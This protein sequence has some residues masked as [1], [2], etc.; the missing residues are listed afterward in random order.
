MQP[1]TVSTTGRLAQQERVAELNADYGSLTAQEIVRTAASQLFFDRLACV[2][3]FGA[4]AAVLLHMVSHYAASAPVVFLDTGKHF[5]ETHTYVTTLIKELGLGVVV[6]AYPQKTRIEVE[7]PAGDLHGRDQDRCCH[8]RK[9]QPMLQALRPYQAF[10][11]GRKRSQTLDRADLQP[12]EAFGKWVRINP[13][14]NWSREEINGYFEEHDLPRHELVARRYFSIGCA[15]CTR[16][17]AEGEDERAG[18]W[19]DTDKT[20][21]GI[22]IAPDGKITRSQGTGVAVPQKPTES[23]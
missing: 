4:E 8:L 14:W 11:T 1:G 16:A 15:P 18:R 22:H 3:S 10:L 20:E 12:F 23:I 17:V 21:C 2:S 9:T 5:P 19:A 7:D 6:S 13:L